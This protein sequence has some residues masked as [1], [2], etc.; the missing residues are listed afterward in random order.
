MGLGAKSSD[1]K[2][3][4]LYNERFVYKDTF[5]KEQVANQSGIDMGKGN[6][7]KSSLGYIA[8]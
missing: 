3:F 2:Y 1:G 5:G 6:L 4:M 8:Y 7:T